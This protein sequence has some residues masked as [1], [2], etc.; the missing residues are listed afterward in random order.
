MKMVEAV[1]IA[2]KAIRVPVILSSGE[3]DI[4]VKIKSKKVKLA[5]TR[6]I[7]G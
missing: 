2:T 7:K 3:I 5:S 1:Q 4:V 6:C